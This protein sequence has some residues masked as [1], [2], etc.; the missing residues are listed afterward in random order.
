[1]YI[2][3][4]SHNKALVCDAGKNRS[5]KSSELGRFVIFSL[6][7]GLN[8]WGGSMKY[9]GAPADAKKRRRCAE[10]LYFH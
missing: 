4:K 2:D 6:V 7:S 1:M 10:P 5:E 3:T 8:Y 9:H